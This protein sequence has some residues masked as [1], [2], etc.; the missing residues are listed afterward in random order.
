MKKKIVNKINTWVKKTHWYNEVV[1]KDCRKFWEMN[2]ND[3]EVV[4]LGSTSG[5]YDFDYSCIDINGANWAVAPQTMVGDF[6]I[7]QQYHDRLKRGATVIYPFCPFTSISGAAEYVEDRCYSFLDFNLIP[8]AHYIRLNKILHIKESPW[9]YYPICRIKSDIKYFLSP[10]KEDYPK[11][12][13]SFMEKDS[14]N[15]LNCWKK[16]FGIGDLSKMFVGRNKL[17]YDKGVKLLNIISAYCKENHLRLII[18]I[19]PMHQSLASLFSS[20]ERINLIDNFVNEGIDSSVQYYNMMD[21]ER[22]SNN[23]SLFRNSYYF[24][25]IGAKQY[26]DFL[27]KMIL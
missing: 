1:F 10:T 16:Q 23:I 14:L 13:D 26:T 25:P 9:L 8:N 17:L 24:N 2:V 18:V 5:V 4:N 27:L 11:L 3:I 20:E 21:D 6:A 15:Y 12:D 22:F 19:P 7:L